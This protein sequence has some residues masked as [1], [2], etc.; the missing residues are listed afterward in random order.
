MHVNIHVNRSRQRK[1]AKWI[2]DARKAEQEYLLI[3][4]LFKSGV[5]MVPVGMGDK[6]GKGSYK[7]RRDEGEYPTLRT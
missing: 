2:K 5:R 1:S 3:L 4:E 6:M 7:S